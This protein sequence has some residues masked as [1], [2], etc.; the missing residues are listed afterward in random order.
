MPS[1]SLRPLFRI[2]WCLA[3][4]AWLFPGVVAAS[5]LLERRISVDFRHTPLKNAMEEVARLG[6]F[7]WSYNAAILPAGEKV[8]LR[9]DNWT[10]REILFAMLG[11]DY[12]FKPS[13]NY[14]ILKKRRRPSDELSGYI[15]D[16]RTGQR[17]AN[18]SVYDRRT[19]RSTTTDD[20]GYYR[21]KK[22][23]REAELVVAKLGYRDTVL[24]ITSTSPRF[25]KIELDT[26]P[27]QTATQ[28]KPFWETAYTDVERFF[29][30]TADRWTELNVRDSLTRQYQ[31][32][33][34]PF[35]GTNHRLS[36]RVRNDY[37]LNI[38][39]GQS[40][41]VNRLEIGGLAN[42]TRESVNGVQ[43]GGL[44]NWLRGDN[45]GVQVGGLFNIARDTSSGVQVGGLYNAA[46]HSSGVSGQ[47][48]GLNNFAG[49]GTCTFQVAGIYN[50][51][52]TVAG[53]QVAGIANR[54]KKVRGVQ[55]GL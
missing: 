50:Q 11:E 9:A 54:A 45:R 4:S 30:K 14:L 31:V 47:V 26:F 21:L 7:Q 2:C 29:A 51:A 48:A 37:S 32:S 28:D 35:V 18:A 5:E 20:N 12:E 42:F 33:F 17:L 8:T 19:L 44:F 55:I 23:G 38:L 46:R 15:S 40:M 36:S 3:L 49:Q 52:D 34:L 6:Q 39:A 27:T 10:V 43:I 24:Q 41:A 1:V 22:T 53:V 16:P 25:Q 13:G